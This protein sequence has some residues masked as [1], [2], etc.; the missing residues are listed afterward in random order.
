MRCGGPG[1]VE[2]GSG[3]GLVRTAPECG[4]R[5]RGRIPRK[6]KDFI[7]IGILPKEYFV[8]IDRRETRRPGGTGEAGLRRV[9]GVF[10][11]AMELP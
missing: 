6:D 2:A 1:T 7:R 9:G 8:E 5:T 3:A 10:D 4:L 11:L